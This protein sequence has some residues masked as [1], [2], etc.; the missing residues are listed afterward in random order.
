[1][2]VAEVKSILGVSMG[3]PSAQSS[4]SPAVEVFDLPEGARAE[5]VEVALCVDQDR[6]AYLIWFYQGRVIRVQKT[7]VPED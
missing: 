4:G 6:K 5:D 2:T 7:T 1:M 3:E